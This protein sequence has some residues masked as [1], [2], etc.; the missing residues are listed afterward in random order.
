MSLKRALDGKEFVVTSE[1]HLPHGKAP[2]DYLTEIYNFWGRGDG[3]RFETFATD[4][5]ISDSLGLCRLLGEKKFDP[6]LQ[7]GT[8]ERNRLEIQED[9]VEAS[10]VGVENL[11]VFSEDYRITGDSFQE[12]MFFH[13]DVGKFFSVVDS[14]KQGTDIH[15]KDLDEEKDFFIGSGIDAG[16]A[17]PPDMGLREMEKIVEQ[18]ARFFLTTPVFDVERFAGFVKKVEPLGVPIIAELLVLHDAMQARMLT[19][20]AGM[21]IPD[22]IIERIEDAPMKFDESTRILLETAEQLR[23]IC[24]GVHILSFGWETKIGT[25]IQKIKRHGVG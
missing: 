20:V 7:V 15:G 8:R 21:H 2:E 16:F 18:G 25:V 1:I 6:V 10:S 9:L 24:A 4:A 13:V 17:T 12:M 11:L 22:H 23:G 5:A 3:V 14:L 19:R